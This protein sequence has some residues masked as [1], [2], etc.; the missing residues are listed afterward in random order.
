M[1]ERERVAE[2]KRSRRGRVDLGEDRR[3]KALGEG[4]SSRETAL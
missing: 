3:E 1:R 4:E 2:R